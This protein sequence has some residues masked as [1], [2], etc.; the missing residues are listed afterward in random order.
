MR[1][2]RNHWAQYL[3][4]NIWE[5]HE[6]TDFPQGGAGL[7]RARIAAYVNNYNRRSGVKGGLIKLRT[8]IKA[9]DDGHVVVYV[10]SRP[11]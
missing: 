11:A 8:A 7:Y 9:A 5:F 6:G 4:G 10:Q 1:Y 3:D 2:P